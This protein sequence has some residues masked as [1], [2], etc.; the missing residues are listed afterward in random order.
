VIRTADELRASAV[1][2]REITSD[3]GDC[4]MRASLL[5]VADE[6]EQK[7]RRAEAFEDAMILSSISG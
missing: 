5:L 7:A 6:L 3:S 2:F 1:R 4:W